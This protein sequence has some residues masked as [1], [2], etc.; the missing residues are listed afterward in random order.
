MKNSIELIDAVEVKHSYATINNIRYHFAEA[1]SGPTVILIH[2][3]ST[4]LLSKFGK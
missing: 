4:G 2:G 1:G 3:C